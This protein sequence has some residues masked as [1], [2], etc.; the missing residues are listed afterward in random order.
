MPTRN[1]GQLIADAGDAAQVYEPLADGIY[2]LKI[3]GAEHKK[4]ASQKDGYNITAEVE[5]G[6]FKGRKVFNT[7]WVSPDSPI[8]MGI[9][10]R[11][12]AALGLDKAFFD[13]EPSDEQIVA[14]LQGK[15]M[16]AT[17]NTEEYNG[18]KNNRIRDVQPPVGPAPASVGGLPGAP[19]SVPSPVAA[20]APVAP[21]APAAVAPPAQA[22]PWA[23]AA[24]PA[25]SWGTPDATAAFA[26]PPAPPAPVATE[27]PGQALPAPPAPALGTTAAP[28]PPF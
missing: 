24:V 27:Q 20:P 13:R 9:F 22:D 4:S 1:W 16:R 11:Q 14:A 28:E 21:P 8:A 26:A 10:F 15:R 7:F 12:F 25:G 3:T 19:V 6:P 23:N 5:T 17:L 18:K 2:D